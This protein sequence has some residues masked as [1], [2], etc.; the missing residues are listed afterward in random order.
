MH[1]RRQQRA[2]RRFTQA[3]GS[4]IVAGLVG[5]VFMTVSSTIE[6]KVS[7]RGSSTTPADAAGKVA[8][9]RPRDESG[10]Q[11][12]NS[13]AHWGYGTAWGLGRSALDLVGLR[14]IPASAAHFALVLGAEQA[15]LPAL[16]VGKPTPA[17]GAQAIATDALHHS[18]YTAA[19]GVAYDLLQR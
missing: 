18:V 9:V 19:T 5:T 1:K 17:Y 13:L 6:A 4:G 11:R 7:G 8:G 16:G 12:F 10:E 15:I 2:V 3:L 14:G